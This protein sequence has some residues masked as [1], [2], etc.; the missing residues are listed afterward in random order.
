MNRMKITLALEYPLMQQGGTEVLVRE[1]IPGLRRHFE[2]VLVSG[3]R[4]IRDLPKELAGL[5][6]RHLTWDARNATAATARAL[7]NSLRGEKVQLAHFHFGGTY[8]WRSNRFWQ[9]PVVH[10]AKLGVPCL[11]TNHLAMEWLNCGCNPARPLWQKNLYQL[12]AIFSRSMVYRRLKLEVCVSQQDRR[13]VAAMFPLFRRKIIQRYHS[14][15]PADAPPPNLQD[16]DPVVLCVGT[17]GGRKAQPDLAGAFARIAGRHPEWQ[18]RFI[19]RPEDPADVDRIRSGASKAGIS[20]RV[21]LLGRL[22][23]EETLHQMQRASI[24]AMPSLQE[25]LGLSLQEALFHGCVGVGSRVGGIPE[26]IEHEV[27][28]LLVPPGD[29]AALSAALDRLMSDPAL[30]DRF[31]AQSRASILRKGMTSAAMV[32]NYLDLYQKFLPAPRLA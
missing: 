12:F 10:L 3:D 27:N 19:G 32:Q 30:L 20:D 13:R 8:E 21:H 5:V 16:R 24:I 7:A 29:V 14:L 15:L 26:L 11:S 2:I 31:R 28:G 9:C 22:S 6:S 25:G 18:L 1:L 23:D 17:I 4:Q